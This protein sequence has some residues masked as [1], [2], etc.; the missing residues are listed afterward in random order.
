MRLVS[1]APKQNGA[2]ILYSADNKPI[3]ESKQL[4]LIMVGRV[5]N[6]GS[7]W[8]D[9]K[10]DWGSSPTILENLNATITLTLNK[11]LKIYKL[12]PEGKRGNLLPI[13]NYKAQTSGINTPLLE[14]ESN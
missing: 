1:L 14:I 7:S 11:N 3:E 12:T 8:K 10:L 4:V 13:L 5:K 2:I 9:D 6:S